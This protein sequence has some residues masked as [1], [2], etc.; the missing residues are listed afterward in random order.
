[1]RYFFLA[2][3]ASARGRHTSALRGRGGGERGGGEKKDLIESGT[4][5]HKEV[6][7]KL[8]EHNDTSQH[9]PRI[10][11]VAYAHIPRDGGGEGREGGEGGGGRG[12]RQAEPFF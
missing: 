5:G 10:R 6:K 3:T 7:K 1:M 11:S 12:R 9:P 8:V 2:H 4:F